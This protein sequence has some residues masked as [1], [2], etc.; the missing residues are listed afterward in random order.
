MDLGLQKSGQLVLGNEIRWEGANSISS[1][2]TSSD[3]GSAREGEKESYDD[4]P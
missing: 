3:A 4:F 2:A 1:C